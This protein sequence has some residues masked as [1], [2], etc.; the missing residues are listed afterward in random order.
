MYCQE[1]KCRPA[2]DIFRAF[3]RRRMDEDY[4]SHMREY[5]RG[6]VEAMKEIGKTGPFWKK[7]KK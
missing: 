5:A 1:I 2:Q 7:P 4:V 3:F 6:M